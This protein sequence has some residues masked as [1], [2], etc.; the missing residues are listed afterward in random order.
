[1]VSA[2]ICLSLVSPNPRAPNGRVGGGFVT[3]PTQDILSLLCVCN[4]QSSLYYPRP[5]ALLTLLQYVCATFVQ[6]MTPPR[7][8]LLMPYTIQYW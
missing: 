2:F 3:W 6:Y 7:P 1:M 4:N 8:S 5:C